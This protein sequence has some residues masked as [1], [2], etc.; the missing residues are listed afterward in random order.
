MATSSETTAALPFSGGRQGFTVQADG[1]YAM[2]VNVV[3]GGGG[4]GGG[5]AA[6]IADGA[7]VAQGARANA[8]ATD[9]TGSW[10]IVS[11]LK[12]LFARLPGL[13]TSGGQMVEGTQAVGAT[14]TS[15]PISVAYQVRAQA[16]AQSVG[17]MV[18]PRCDSTGMQYVALGTSNSSNFASVNAAN[19]ATMSQVTQVLFTGAFSYVF[20]GTNF[21]RASGDTQGAYTKQPTVALTDRSIAATTTSQQ[22]LAANPTRNKLRIQN[23]ST[24][25]DLWYNY[26]SAAVVGGLGSFKL[27]PGAYLDEQG[28]NQ[29]LFVIA[30]TGT[31]NA[32]I[33]ES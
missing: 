33:K 32:T 31:V 13:G 25:G 23:V 9:S 10:S 16:P 17:G 18:I 8:A 12:G 21:L 29:A 20:D 11:L 5:G 15:N 30:S 2:D 14:P 6:T 4:G 27:V 22:A 24:T 1:T 26:G 3:G 28:T 7:D 19:N